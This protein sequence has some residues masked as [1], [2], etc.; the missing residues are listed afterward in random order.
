VGQIEDLRMFALVVENRSISKAALRLNIAK[1]AVSRRLTLLEERFGARLV[2]RAPGVWAVTPVGRELYQRAV[3]LVGDMDEINSDFVEI[4]GTIAGPLSVSVPQDFGIAFLNASLL[5][6][7]KNYPEIQLTVDFDDRAVDLTRENYDFA[8]RVTPKIEPGLVAQ[9]IGSSAHYLCASPQYLA[10]QGHPET[11]DDLPQHRLLHFGNARRASWRFVDAGGT[12]HEVDFQPTLNSNN[13][14]FLLK[15][16]ESGLGIAHLPDFIAAGGLA[17]GR[18]L[19]VLP[20]VSVGA[21]GIFLVH[22]EDRRLNRRMRLFTDQMKQ[23]CTESLRVR[24][25]ATTL[26]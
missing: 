24:G 9:K 2:D 1:S 22:A 14:G 17:N 11:P 10:A 20:E 21:W 18:L 7:K 25:K 4:S 19:R 23:A 12:V 3:R 5:A 13:G 26:T 16:A 15:A 6:F 8:I